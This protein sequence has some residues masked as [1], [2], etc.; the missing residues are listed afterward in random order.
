MRPK[1]TRRAR[2]ASASTALVAVLGVVVFGAAPALADD[3][4]PDSPP[5]SSADADSPS[6]DKDKGQD[7][8]KEKDKD[9]SD[10]ATTV[11]TEAFPVPPWPPPTVDMSQNEPPATPKPDHDYEQSTDC[12]KSGVFDELF[13]PQ[14]WAHKALQLHQ[15]HKIAN[16]AG[17][18]VALIDTGVYHN[19]FFQNRLQS[20][21]DYVK[22]QKKGL[23]DCDGHGTE[24]AGIMAAD[25]HPNDAHKKVGFD[26]VA[27]HATVYSTRTTSSNW[28]WKDDQDN[29]H[30]AGNLHTL[31]QAINHLVDTVPDL[32][33]INISLTACVPVDHRVS[34]YYHFLQAAIHHAV[35]KDV[36]VVAAA[37][38][39]SDSSSEGCT[40][41]NNSPDPEQLKMIPIPAWFG[42]DVL[43]VAAMGRKGNPAGFSVHGPWVDVAAPG[44]EIV[45]LDPA[46]DGIVNRSIENDASVNAS[47]KKTGGG[48]GGGQQ[49]PQP[50]QGT[51]FA[52][53]YVSGLVALVR[54][55]YPWLNAHQVMHRVE[56]TAQHPAGPDGRNMSVGYG[57]IN[58][59]AALTDIV[60]GEP[61]KDG[62]P[63]APAAKATRLPA[64]LPQPE[65][66]NWAAV[67]VALG[68][69]GGG[70][71]LLL[72]TLFVVHTIRRNRRRRGNPA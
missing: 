58:P 33:V 59:M 66:N 28:F 47:G 44:T 50:I 53:P 42:K 60:P 49:Q 14:S 3:P 17:Q 10:E 38:N 20:G 62:G 12:I 15:V 52:A 36:V 6:H 55:K 21:G 32:A 41:N 64:A 67:V 40:G 24:V 16:G 11:P 39:T 22:E 13:K 23:E 71:A 61:G 19:Q 65:Q 51:S 8:D 2:L 18:K 72:V 45:S 25:T 46:G 27:P 34:G 5:S 43:T 30:H 26:G 4:P 1:R 48:T 35:E 31:G 29:K 7:S 54:E 70:V 37:G 56:M 69:T 57:M 9:D 68:G 63:A